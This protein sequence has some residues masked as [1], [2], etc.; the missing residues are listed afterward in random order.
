MITENTKTKKFEHK[1][2]L[3]AKKPA[4]LV[5][6]ASKLDSVQR[7]ISMLLPQIH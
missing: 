7:V 2:G 3:N 6:P 1:H 5:S 4:L